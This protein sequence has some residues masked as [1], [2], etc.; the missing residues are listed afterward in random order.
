MASDGWNKVLQFLGIIEEYEDEYAETPARSQPVPDLGDESAASG[1]SRP[2]NVRRIPTAG[3][4]EDSPLNAPGP[5]AAPP[6]SEPSGTVN[7]IGGPNA[8]PAPSVSE[9]RIVDRVHTT[10]PAAFNDVEGIGEQFR[11]GTPVAMDLRGCGESTAKRILDFASGLIY[12]LEGSIERTGDRVFLL[13][14]HD[15]DVAI[16]AMDRLRDEGLVD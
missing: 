7:V 12:G 10:Q 16:T 15:T 9:P 2:T 4:V 3:S 14:P 13:I 8:A 6:P 11:A 1:R 5:A